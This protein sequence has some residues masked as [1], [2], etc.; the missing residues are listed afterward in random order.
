MTKSFSVTRIEKSPLAK[1][2][3]AAYAL[4]K[5][6]NAEDPLAV[7]KAFRPDIPAELLAKLHKNNTVV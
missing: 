2:V 3:N 7:L 4:A 1:R 5:T 6:I